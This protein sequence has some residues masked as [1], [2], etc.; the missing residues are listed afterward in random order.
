MDKGS[1]KLL[2]A[3]DIRMLAWGFVSQRGPWDADIEIDMK[4]C[5]EPQ[6][7][8]HCPDTIPVKLEVQLILEILPGQTSNLT[9]R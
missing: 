6:S 5:K 8:E 4:P 1:P 9:R 3:V 7:S 2:V